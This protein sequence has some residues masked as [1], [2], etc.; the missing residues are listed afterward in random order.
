EHPEEL[1]R[2]PDQMLQAIEDGTLHLG[3]GDE[4]VGVDPERECYPAGQGTGAIQDLVPAGELVRR[5]VA[6]AEATLES[7]AGLRATT[8]A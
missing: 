6:E 3:G 1:K 7:I 5:F 4:A 2:F 8:R